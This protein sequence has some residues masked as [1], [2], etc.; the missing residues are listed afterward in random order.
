[1]GTLFL[2]HLSDELHGLEDDLLLFFRNLQV[3]NSRDRLL[4]E[5]REHLTVIFIKRQLGCFAFDDNGANTLIRHQRHP[6]DL[7]LKDRRALR[8]RDLIRMDIRDIFFLRNNVV[9]LVIEDRDHGE[10][11][12]VGPK[13][14]DRCGTGMNELTQ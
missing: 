6:H 5:D 7:R 2:E 1:M 13:K 11:L 9:D 8:D 10:L 12:A 4:G 3:P 14:V